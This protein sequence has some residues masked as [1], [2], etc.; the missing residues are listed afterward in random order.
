MADAVM[1]AIVSAVGLV[2]SGVLSDHLLQHV[3]DRR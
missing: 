1:V 2:M 3:N